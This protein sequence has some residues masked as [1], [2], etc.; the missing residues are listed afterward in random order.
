MIIITNMVMIIMSIIMVIILVVNLTNLII[1]IIINILILT[2]IIMILVIAIIMV[3]NTL[4]SLVTCHSQITQSLVERERES[5]LLEIGVLERILEE[6][7]YQLL[8]KEIKSSCCFDVY[9]EFMMEATCF[10]QAII[11][12][13]FLIF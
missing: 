10:F 13:A 6:S 1:M 3:N 9:E 2:I 12:T 4:L 11:L 8:I 7:V 5:H